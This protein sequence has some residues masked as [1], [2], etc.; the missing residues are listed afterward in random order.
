M[1]TKLQKILKIN[2]AQM[3]KLQRNQYKNS[4]LCGQ[5]LLTTFLLNNKKLFL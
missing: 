1:S 2:F 5:R 4:D 3:F